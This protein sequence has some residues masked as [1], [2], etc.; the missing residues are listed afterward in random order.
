MEIMGFEPMTSRMQS[1]R[2]TTEL[3]PRDKWVSGMQQCEWFW[4]LEKMARM[5]R[6]E[7]GKYQG[8]DWLDFQGN[9]NIIIVVPVR[10][11]VILLHTGVV[12]S[13]RT[14]QQ[15]SKRASGLQESRYSIPC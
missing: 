15:C 8:V 7:T 13:V 2:S 5:I 3:N 4:R 1:E 12:A 10:V 9:A 11:S 6:D 14:V